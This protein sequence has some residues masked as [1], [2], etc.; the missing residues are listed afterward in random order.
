MSESVSSVWLEL[1]RGQQKTLICMVYREFSDLVSPGQM[2]DNEQRDRWQIFMDQAKRA[3]KE[4]TV[5]ACGDMNL[6]LDKFEDPNYY[7]KAL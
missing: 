2:S 7:K 6:D 4:G 3:S 5:L 1:S